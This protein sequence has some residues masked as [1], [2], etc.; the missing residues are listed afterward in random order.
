MN[1]QI[2]EIQALT[3]RIESMEKILVEIS[4]GVLPQT[5][6]MQGISRRCGL[7]VKCLYNNDY[8]YYLPNFGK[9]DYPD[10][11]IRWDRETVEAWYSIDIEEHKRTWVTMARAERE[12]IFKAS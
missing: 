1:I 11:I 10:G 4:K 5:I 9:S 7:S 8:R 6:N 2:P 3:K 12:K